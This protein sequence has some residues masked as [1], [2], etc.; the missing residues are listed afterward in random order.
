M[1]LSLSGQGQARWW[2]GLLTGCGLLQGAELTSK[3]ISC[4]GAWSAAFAESG[5]S[6]DLGHWLVGVRLWTGSLKATLPSVGFVCL[7]VYCHVKW[8]LGHIGNTWL[9]GSLCWGACEKVPGERS[10]WWFCVIMIT[11]R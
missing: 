4:Q 3:M 1:G 11:G 9:V 6:E 10:I 5:A 7:F 2:R 8:G